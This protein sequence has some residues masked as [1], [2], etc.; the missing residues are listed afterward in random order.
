MTKN[1]NKKRSNLLDRCLRDVKTGKLWLSPTDRRRYQERFGE[2][3][4]KVSE[5]FAG[6]EALLS[7]WCQSL[8]PER[9]IVL[10]ELVRLDDPSL[11]PLVTDLEHWPKAQREEY[12][13]L[14]IQAKLHHLF[15]I[16]E[17]IDAWLEAYLCDRC[18]ALKG[19]LEFDGEAIVELDQA[20]TE[21]IEKRPAATSFP[22]ST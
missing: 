12:L 7:A 18:V 8:S 17:V 6:E 11:P 1:R 14:R 20:L 16:R 5:P 22:L 13:L 15:E 9:G 4:V 2:L 19:T 3:G 10:Y 21:L